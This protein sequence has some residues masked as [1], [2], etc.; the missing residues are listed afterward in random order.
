MINDKGYNYNILK[1]S[2]FNVFILWDVACVSLYAHSL[3]LTL[4]VFL[5]F[6]MA[7]QTLLETKPPTPYFRPPPLG[8]GAA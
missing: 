6:R 7:L 2:N 1:R 4:C 8:G 5:Y 3:F